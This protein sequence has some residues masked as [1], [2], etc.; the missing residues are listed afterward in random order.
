MTLQRA[1]RP[2]VLA[3]GLLCVFGM[4]FAPRATAANGIEPSDVVLAFDFSAS[5]AEAGK[6]IATASALDVLAERIPKYKDDILASDIT[7]HLVV[8]RGDASSLPGC[9]TIQLASLERIN[10]F[11]DCLSTIANLYRDGKQAWKS[12][13]GASSGTNYEAA[14]SSTVSILSGGTASR[15]A[16]IFFADGEHNPGDGSSTAGWLDRV[17]ANIDTLPARGV[18][19]VGLGV[20]G[21]AKVALEKLR[22]EGNLLVCPGYEAN[23]LWKEVAFSNGQIAGD[24]V[25]AAFARVTCVHVDEPPA[26]PSAPQPPSVSAGDG[27]VVASVEPPASNGSPISGY[28]WEC[29]S[30]AGGATVSAESTLPE[31]TISGTE[32]GQEYK[33]RASATNGVGTG[34]WSESS[35]SVSPCSGLLGCNPWMLPLFL[36][37]L[38]LLLLLALALLLWYLRARKRLYVVAST[39][40]FPEVGLLRGPKTGMSFVSSMNPAEVDGVRRDIQSTA[41]VGIENLGGGKFKWVDRIGGT[42]GTVEQGATFSVNDPSGTPRQIRLREYWTNPKISS[43]VSSASVSSAAWGS[44][45][46]TGGDSGWDNSSSAGGGWS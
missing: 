34:P 43:S 45:S 6:N 23:S 24:R 13:V 38:L 40:G 19:P 18:L 4:S 9:Q 42:S 3:V 29:N 46:S 27:S 5:M 30:V 16:I 21:K 44:S 39:S 2:F 32:N 7:V 41:N 10:D 33:C 11:A 17:I 1:M 14:F 28:Q 25:A 20:K 22:N 26:A 37:L 36:L 8:F 35:S 15:P 31:T 12:Q